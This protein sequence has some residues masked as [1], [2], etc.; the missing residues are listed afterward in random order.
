MAA[1]SASGDVEYD[2]DIEGNFEH[3]HSDGLKKPAGKATNED[4][5]VDNE[6]F[7]DDT[8]E[9]NAEEDMA[10]YCVNTTVRRGHSLATG[11]PPRPDTS[12]MTAVE[13]K[14]ATKE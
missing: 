4:V 10:Y 3:L 9:D 5:Y 14:E 6:L 11:G 1:A 13:T 2:S 7:Q 12:G 8:T